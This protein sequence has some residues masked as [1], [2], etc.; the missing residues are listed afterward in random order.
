LQ[1][2]IDIGSKN[3]N[4]FLSSAIAKNEN[5]LSMRFYD[6]VPICIKMPVVIKKSIRK[7][8]TAQRSFL[9][10]FYYNLEVFLEYYYKKSCFLEWF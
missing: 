6:Y 5:T 4:I 2:H 3:T 8:E 9:S 1:N 7:K 10:R